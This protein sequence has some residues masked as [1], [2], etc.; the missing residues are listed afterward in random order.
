MKNSIYSIL[1]IISMII[2]VTNYA[3]AQMAPQTAYIYLHKNA[4]DENSSVDFSF[5]VTGPN[6]FAKT[7]NL[8]DQHPDLSVKDIGATGNGGLYAVADNV[9]GTT[10]YGVYY[11]A[12][13]ASTWVKVSGQQATRIDGGPDN[14]QIHMNN[15]G[16]LYHFSG[17]VGAILGGS[18]ASDV[19]YDK[20]GSDRMFYINKTGQGFYRNG[21]AGTWTSITGLTA[22]AIAVAPSGRLISVG[23]A[24]RNHVWITNYDGTTPV[25]LGLVAGQTGAIFD[26]G[27][28]G[29]GVIYAIA[30]DRTAYRYNGSYS[31]G[32][33]WV[34]EETSRNSYRITG[35]VAGQVWLTGPLSSIWTRTGG[36]IWLDD[37]PILSSPSNSNSV[38]IPVNPG[39]Y[40]VVENP[41][42]GWTLGAIDIY[43]TSNNSSATVGIATS[44]V[45][46]SGGEV[47]HVVYK[48]FLIK[49]FTVANDCATSAY[50]EDFGSGTVG[51]FSPALTGQTNYH[52]VNQPTFLQD[53]QYMVVGNSGQADNSGNN[54]YGNYK[55]HTTGDGTG[56]MMV[57]NA[58]YDKGEF[59][60]RRFTGLITGVEYSFSAWIMNLNNAAIKPNV[61]FQINNAATKESIMSLSTGNVT[62][63]GAWTQYQLMFTAN[64]ADVDIV[65]RNNNIGGAGNDL[66]L[67]DIRFG[68]AQPNQPISTKTDAT[69]TT[70]GSIEI[71]SPTGLSIEYSL[72]GIT[73]Q[74]NAIFSSVPAG[75]YN[76]WARYANSAG[77]AVMAAATIVSQTPAPPL[78]PITGEAKPCGNSSY[79]YQNFT[80]G[81]VWSISPSNYGTIDPVTGTLT[82]NPTA[83][84][85]AVITYTVTSGTC[86]SSTTYDIVVSLVDCT[87]MPVTL[88][89][90]TAQNGENNE[91]VLRWA[92]TEESNSREFEIQHSLKGKAWSPMGSVLA[93]GES[94]NLVNYSFTDTSPVSGENLYRLK[95]IDKDDTYT[96]SRIRSVLSNVTGLKLNI[97][98]NPVS[99][100]LLVKDANG[101]AVAWDK[102]KDV[103]IVNT[104]GVVVYKLTS[105]VS[106]DGINVSG[107]ATGI[108]V[109]KITLADGTLST[110]KVMVGR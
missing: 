77:C 24:G 17:T 30:S 7:N 38:L 63:V 100:L 2:S 42:T 10:G 80:S 89:H 101:N 79:T 32:G 1:L 107:L 19:A 55:D 20:S 104:Q 39:S 65:L 29:D 103:S 3:Y 11:K 70:N 36:G 23:S 105:P 59:F 33:T 13:D 34:K 40:T 4:T 93:K 18:N 68:L 64:H 84:G 44:T 71:T 46:V 5:N 48:N 86:V 67:D 54:I 62:T 41:A 102:V 97:H 76:V 61:E 91:V 50:F 110:H 94:K 16:D 37:Q 95:M 52:Y 85:S 83:D 27:V 78:D 96:Y 9:M 75:T 60:R 92:T 22:S 57:V 49:S 66:A 58:S 51:S 73:F 35:G 43:D 8:N 21:V 108:Y 87:P 15:N 28:A 31:A 98:P 12:A 53:G 74:S 26:V 88:V 47:V 109:V 82:T 99:E 6:G 106:S 90:F 45:N 56:Y 81:G 72:D 69:C 14:S 25:D